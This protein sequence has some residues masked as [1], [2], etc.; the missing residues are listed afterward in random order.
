MIKINY[1]QEMENL[2]KNLDGKKTLLLHSCCGPC[3]TAVITKLKDFFDITVFY[4]NPSLYPETEYEKRRDEQIKFLN[5]LNKQEKRN[6]KIIVPTFNPN[7]FYDAIKKVE[8]FE[9]L[10]EGGM[11]CYACYKERLEATAKFAKQN[12]FDFFGTTLSVSPYKHSD[13]LNEIGINLQKELGI[14][15]LV[16]DFKKKDGYKLSQDLSKKFNLYRQNY[17]GC[18]FSLK[19]QEEKETNN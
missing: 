11:R 10:K 2:I 5:A 13:W 3:S 19:E 7:T 8:N 12:N 4:Y 16:S 15:F 6:I 17:C 9:K 14:K 1:N 18:V